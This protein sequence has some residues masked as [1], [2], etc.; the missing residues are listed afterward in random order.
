MKINSGKL[1]LTMA[2][3]NMSVSQLVEKSGVSRGTVSTVKL[4]GT[5]HISTAAKLAA[6]LGV[7][8]EEIISQE[9]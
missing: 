9:A 6:A 7:D 5:C 4:R 2:R 8:V 1:E 3:K